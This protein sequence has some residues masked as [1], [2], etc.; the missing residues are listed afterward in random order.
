M[1]KSVLKITAYLTLL[2]GLSL[3]LLIFWLVANPPEFNYFITKQTGLIFK[4]ESVKLHAP[5]FTQ[6]I[7]SADQVTITTQNKY[8]KVASLQQVGLVWDMKSLFRGTL[9]IP[10]LLFKDPNIQFNLSSSGKIRIGDWDVPLL[11]SSSSTLT[12]TVK[13]HQ[14]SSKGGNFQFTFPEEWQIPPVQFSNTEVFWN[15]EQEVIQLKSRYTWGGEN[16]QLGGNF[17]GKQGTWEGQFGLYDLPLHI[18]TIPGVKN[19]FPE[20][21]LAGKFNLKGQF[22]AKLGGTWKSQMSWNLIG[23]KILN[24]KFK[25]GVL[26]INMTG[27]MTFLQEPGQVSKLTIDRLH[28]HGP[29]GPFQGK[30]QVQFP[31]DDFPTLN[32]TVTT[33]SWKTEAI[34]PYLFGFMPDDVGIWIR[35]HIFEGVANTVE[36]TI[37]GQLNPDFKDINE[38]LHINLHAD[39]SG[40]HVEPFE[41]VPTI[42]NIHGDLHLGL[43]GIAIEADQAQFPGSELFGASLSIGYGA[44]VVTPFKLEVF[45]KSQTHILWPQLRPM[46]EDLVPEL[47]QL[48]IIGTSDVSFSLIDDNMLDDQLMDLKLEVIPETTD[49]TFGFN[50]QQ[51]EATDV[52]G[53]FRATLDNLE[54]EDI[55]FKSDKLKGTFNGH[56]PFQPTQDMTLQLELSQ[57]E[58]FMPKFQGATNH[59][60]ATWFPK[61]Y[62]VFIESHQPWPSENNGVWEFSIKGIDESQNELNALVELQSGNLT[63]PYIQGEMGA[64]LLSGDVNLPHNQADLQ[65]EVQQTGDLAHSLDLFWNQ[66]T[67]TIAIQSDRFQ[68]KDWQDWKLPGALSTLLAS[69]GENP[70]EYW[71]FNINSPAVMIDQSE[72]LPIQLRGKLEFIPHL[73]LDITDF[74]IDQHHGTF[75]FEQHAQNGFVNLELDRL[76]VPLWNERFDR[77]QKTLT[78]VLA[79]QWIPN[80]GG[81]ELEKF[82]VEV[83]TNEVILTENFV[84]PLSAKVEFQQI[85][86][87]FDIAIKQMNL[88]NQNISA[89]V[90]KKEEE[91]DISVKADRL[92]VRPWWALLQNDSV[93]TQ[94]DKIVWPDFVKTIHLQFSTGSLFF[95]ETFHPKIDLVST[96]TLP[97]SLDASAM[98]RIHGLQGQVLLPLPDIND[99]IPSP[100]P[101]LGGIISKGEVEI[102]PDRSITS[103]VQWKIPFGVLIHKDWPSGQMKVNNVEGQSDFAYSPQSPLTV[104]TSAQIQA[105]FGRCDCSLSLQGLSES[106]FRLAIEAAS[107]D[108]KFNVL[109]PYLLGI[110]P[111]AAKPFVQTQLH[112]GTLTSTLFQL[113]TDILRETSEPSSIDWEVQTFVEGLTLIPWRPNL[114]VSQMAGEFKMNANV[115]EAQIHQGVLPGGHIEE[116]T[117]SLVLNESQKL[118]LSLNVSGAFDSEV[119]WPFITPNIFDETDRIRQNLILAGKSQFQISWERENLLETPGVLPTI[120]LRPENVWVEWSDAE[121]SYGGTIRSGNIYIVP[122]EHIQWDVTYDAYTLSGKTT[123]VFPFNA[124]IVPNIQLDVNRLETLLPTYEVAMH[125]YTQWFPQQLTAEVEITQTLQPTNPTWDMKLKT[126]DEFGQHLTLNTQW[127][128]ASNI[129][130]QIEG[131]LGKIKLGGNVHLGREHFDID[132]KVLTETP[133]D[134]NLGIR[135]NNASL[136]LNFPYLWWEEWTFWKL[137]PLWTEVLANRGNSTAIKRWDIRLRTPNLHLDHVQ[138]LPVAF[139]GVLTIEPSLSFH[140][141]SF[142]LGKQLASLSLNSGKNKNSLIVSA[143][144]VQFSQLIPRQN[145]VLTRLPQ[146]SKQSNE[147]SPS[148]LDSLEVQVDVG[149]F[150]L[151]GNESMPFYTDLKLTEASTIDIEQIRLGTQEGKGRIHYH[152]GNLNIAFQGKTLELMPWVKMLGTNE[153][154]MES[155]G[156]ST[157]KNIHLDL[158]TERLVLQDELYFPA[159]LEVDFRPSTPE[160]ETVEIQIPYFQGFGQSGEG[161]VWMAQNSMVVKM[162]FNE[163]DISKVLLLDSKFFQEIL[164][165]PDQPSNAPPR[166]DFVHFEVEAPPKDLYVEGS[167]QWESDDVQVSFNEFKWGQQRGTGSV[168]KI[169]DQ[170]R[171][172]GNFSLIDLV[173]WR[174]LFDPQQLF[175]DSI[176]PSPPVEAA[177]KKVFGFPL[178]ETAWL[179]DFTVDRIKSEKSVFDKFVVNGETNSKNIRLSQLSWKRKAEQEFSLSGYLN[180]VSNDGKD[181]H[182][183]GKWS[184]DIADLGRMMKLIFGANSEMVET[185][186]IEGGKTQIQADVQMFPIGINLWKPYA[187]INVKSSEGIVTNFPTAGFLLAMISLQ[188]YLKVAENKLSGFEGKGLVYNT[189]RS[190]ILVDGGIVEVKKLEVASP[191]IRNW[192]EGVWNFETGLQDALFCYQPFETVDLILSQIPVANLILTNKRDAFFEYCYKKNGPL[193]NPELLLVP[194]TFLLGRL[195]DFFLFRPTVGETLARD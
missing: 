30:A 44:P 37:K 165:T 108:W 134:L 46:W 171:I 175:A 174:N 87:G 16:G 31:Q 105:P 120:Q 148:F 191:N 27:Q 23:G 184:S 69:G 117:V 118:P 1:G 61:Q 194:Q 40:V 84:L 49:V 62:S 21:P 55:Q 14:L 152:D 177:P 185:Y 35:D 106:G 52:K 127:T 29:A 4:A 91:L 160:Y 130:A 65:V 178:P 20:M 82:E 38:I 24:P 25:N 5:S 111:E 116:G 12:P 114:E 73:H 77:L 53:F 78:D 157:L 66:N 9:S 94:P 80:S 154:K 39:L 192:T 125:P 10:K 189:V 34:K 96:L 182:W 51:W 64:F 109:K 48:E 129:T 121:E 115:L 18:W 195:R 59:S 166:L 71:A 186:T 159:Q 75:S 168:A 163:L 180:R 124:H 123:G 33:K 2:G 45:G 137:P 57:L 169:D 133:F 97:D 101:F 81:G 122:E 158:E 110:I 156:Q 176:S 47:K 43:W 70:I 74:E 83:Q 63:I 90:R 3:V 98:W 135:K 8:K 22:Q 26:P 138:S 99:A 50:G 187:Q 119:L 92:D 131:T 85:D 107:K 112:D 188:S 140:S 167:V 103:Q 126:T 13:I 147:L 162:N 161:Q 183:E 142:M 146:N 32:A 150:N 86:Q 193:D 151:P 7:V 17:L 149:R 144:K 15:L 54:W 132:A 141:S 153:I 79:S 95:D 173:E 181:D 11:N 58:S 41:G 28:G 19:A 136:D 100:S 170:I 68:W 104:T 42:R 56:F 179:V 67:A 139:S 128:N 102:S 172:N 155:S 72:S 60:M 93:P 145:H 190:D 89:N 76:N 113:N 143:D 6:L 88:G 164:F 36:F